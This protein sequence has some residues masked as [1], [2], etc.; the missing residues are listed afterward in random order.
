[1]K[2]AQ[3]GIQ[4]VSGGNGLSQG[5]RDLADVSMNTVASSNQW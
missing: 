5:Q 4:S 2:T 1:M 3:G